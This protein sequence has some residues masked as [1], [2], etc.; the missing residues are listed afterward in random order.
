MTAE[1]D[2]RLWIVWEQGN[3]VKA[4]H[5]NAAGTRFGS[6]GTWASPRGT[7][8]LWHTAAAGTAGGAGVAITATTQYAI[9][10]WHTNI[11]RTLTIKAS[12][13]SARRGSGVTFTVT[14]AGDPVAGA[15]VRFGTRS[16]TTNGSGRV[17]INAPG[18]SGR[19]KATA[20]K[21]GYNPGSTTVRVR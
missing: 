10:V 21:G 2:G 18:S 13:A 16:G 3:K 8:Y 14:D 4:V 9:N 7:E 17:T 11:T 1:P 5:T 15:T 19:V 20:R 12:P 6:V